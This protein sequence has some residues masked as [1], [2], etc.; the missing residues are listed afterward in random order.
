MNEVMNKALQIA[1]G[2]ENS[3]Y[4]ETKVGFR[5]FTPDFLPVIGYVPNVEGLLA[6]NGLG[7]SGLTSGPYVGAELAS[8][9]L[10]KPT[11]LDID[12]YDIRRAFD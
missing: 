3:T 11:E 8:L 4:V 1:P 9:A 6:A 12:N 7:S 2:L 5:P 10:G